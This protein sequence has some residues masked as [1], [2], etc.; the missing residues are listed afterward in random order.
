MPRVLHYTLFK[1]L[2]TW[3]METLESDIWDGAQLIYFHYMNI[4]LFFIDIK[5]IYI[6]TLPHPFKPLEHH[7][8]QE[9]KSSQ[10]YKILM[11]LQSQETHS[12]LKP[13]VTGAFKLAYKALNVKCGQR[14]P[15]LACKMRSKYYVK[16]EEKRQEILC[17][18]IIFK[19]LV[20][21]TNLNI[22]KNRKRGLIST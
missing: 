22:K 14:T 4:L 16:K 18:S 8:K 17:V 13:C 12:V 11:L 9:C 1:T 21:A 19:P 3:S 7:K 2:R 15:L 6:T 20:F 5:L 10:S